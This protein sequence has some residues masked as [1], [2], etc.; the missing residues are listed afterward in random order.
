MPRADAPAAPVALTLAWWSHSGRECLRVSGWSAAA[1]AVLRGA[2]DEELAVWL[3]VYPTDAVAAR[4]GHAPV[5]RSRLPSTAG[6][7]FLDG[8]AVCFSPR[9]PFLA[10][11]SCTVLVDPTVV[12]PAQKNRTVDVADFAALTITRDGGVAVPSTGVISVSP[13]TATIPR[14]VLRMYVEFSAE[15]DEGYAA[16]CIHLRRA[17]TPEVVADAFLPFDPE[18]WDAS[19]R[20]LTVLFDPARIKRGLAPHQEAGYPLEEGVDVE[21]VVDRCFRDRDGAPLLTEHVQHYHVGCDVRER[22]EPAKWVI[23]PPRAGTARPLVVEFDRPLDR[24]LLGRCLTVLD[25]Q[26]VRI[27]GGTSISN[28]ERSW[29]LVPAESWSTGRYDLVVD[30][31]LEDIA[32]NSV[33]RVFD[34]D[35]ALRDHDPFEGDRSIRSFTLQS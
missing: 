13:A 12:D 1:L 26:G 34:R 28:G 35:L 22:V 2:G 18:L 31:I 10:S 4:D 20:R 24:A 27:S 16:N 11:V 30:P 21:L 3:P 23:H 19:R 17:E 7:Y 8:D 32:G 9:F 25:D 29:S 6:R 15:M 33:A 14:N 5:G